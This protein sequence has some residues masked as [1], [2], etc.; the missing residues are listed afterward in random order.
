MVK[1]FKMTGK[2]SAKQALLLQ[3]AL[4]LRREGSSYEDIALAL[5][6]GKADAFSLVKRAVRDLMDNCALL[7][8]EIR[9]LELDRLDSILKANWAHR[10]S[11]RHADVILKVMERRS[12]LLGLDVAAKDTVMVSAPGCLVI[13]ERQD[14]DMDV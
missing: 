1:M 9:C 13:R 7:V 10:D 4:V 2:N 11:P 3:Q 12:R 8:E 14:G 5:G 6:C